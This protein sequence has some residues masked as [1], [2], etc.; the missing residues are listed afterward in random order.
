MGSKV[1]GYTPDTPPPKS[2]ADVTAYCD[3][4]IRFNLSDVARDFDDV[5]S[6]YGDVQRELRAAILAMPDAPRLRVPKGL[7]LVEW[8]K[9]VRQQVEQ[10]LRER[11]AA[12]QPARPPRGASSTGKRPSVNDR[13]AAMLQEE[14][15]RTDWTAEQWATKLGCSAAAVKQTFTWKKTIRA[16]RA[17]GQA[18][19]A[20]GPDRR[21]R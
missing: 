17:L 5:H 6:L 13:M 16:A 3:A 12:K 14:P 8:L 1:V 4:W 7:G 21:R 20:L 19:R 2:L 10:A 9:E 18:S 15:T 11:P